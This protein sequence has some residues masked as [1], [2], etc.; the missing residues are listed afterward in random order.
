MKRDFLP[1]FMHPARSFIKLVSINSLSRHSVMFFYAR[2]A[3]ITFAAVSIS[4]MNCHDR[5]TILFF[6]ERQPSNIS[7]RFNFHSIIAKYHCG[8]PPNI[9]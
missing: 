5:R 8:R 6:Y 7:D 9:S 4:M 2:R 3:L 1:N